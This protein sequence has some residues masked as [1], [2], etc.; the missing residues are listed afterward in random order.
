MKQFK[1]TRGYRNN[2]PGNIRI[3]SNWQGLSATQ[4]DKS[5]CQFKSKT[6]GCR[7]LAILLNNYIGKGY[8]SIRKIISRYAPSNENNTEAYICTVSRLTNLNSNLI[9][10]CLSKPYGKGNLAKLMSAIICVENGDFDN[11]D[12]WYHYSYCVIDTYL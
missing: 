1:N 6:Y 4:T 9:F 2:N 10:D 11:Y 12:Y 3:G 5:F 7:A 8:N